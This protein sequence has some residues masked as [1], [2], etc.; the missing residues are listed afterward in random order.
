MFMLEG[1]TNSSRWLTL[2]LTWN[3]MENELIKMKYNK[4]FKDKIPKIINNDGK[5]AV[6]HKADKKE[7]YKK[8]KEKLKEEVDEFFISDEEEE[9]ADILEVIY[10]ICDFKKI[11][12]KKLEKIRLNK[13]E[14]KGGFNSRVI[15]D[16]ID[17]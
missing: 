16:R 8:L 12:R 6:T 4:L 7:Y 1:T 11:D 14:S 3:L 5:K 15:L 17:K 13:K 10:E 9:L 2:F